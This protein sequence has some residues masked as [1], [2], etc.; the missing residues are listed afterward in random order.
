MELAANDVRK[1]IEVGKSNPVENQIF[2]KRL[3]VYCDQFIVENEKAAIDEYEK[4]R[5]RQFDGAE[6]NL[7]QGAAILDYSQDL[8]Y[9]ELSEQL[10]DRKKMLDMA[11]KM[12][13][14]FFD[15]E[16]VQVPKVK[17]KG[18]RKDSLNVR[19]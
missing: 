15:K 13:E 12:K 17:V 1:S 6:I 10:A 3:K 16:G 5:Q 8:I 14:P 7:T 18:Y 2:F 9:A 4:D 11:Y 19:L